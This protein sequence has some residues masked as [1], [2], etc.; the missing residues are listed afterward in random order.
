MSK[1]NQVQVKLVKSLIGRSDRH[2]KSI[3]ALGLRKLGD[4]AVLENNSPTQGL[5]RQVGYLLEVEEL[6]A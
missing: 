4:T 3:K 6:L 5:I 2:R 1:P